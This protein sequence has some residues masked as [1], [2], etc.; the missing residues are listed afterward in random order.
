MSSF[1]SLALSPTPLITFNIAVPSRTMDAISSSRHFNIHML[2]GDEHGAATADRFTKGNAQVDHLLNDLKD[3]KQP[4]DTV[5]R[6]VAIPVLDGAGVVYVLRCRVWDGAPEKGLIPV[7]DH[8][9]VVGEVL[10]MIPGEATA[11]QKGLYGLA[12]VDRQYRKVGDV[13]P[14]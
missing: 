2:A 10:E 7:R 12:Y 5:G 11:D 14:K 4:S 1:T 3:S 6:T 8:V 13:L 9:I